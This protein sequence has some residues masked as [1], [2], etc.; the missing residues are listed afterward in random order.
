MKVNQKQNKAKEWQNSLTPLN[1]AQAGQVPIVFKNASGKK[2]T[3]YITLT[4]IE[5]VVEGKNIS[6]G[7]LLTD[8]LNMNM[9]T[10]KKVNTIEKGVA[11]HNKDL[12]IV[13]TDKLGFIKEI[14][15]F[16][17]NVDFVLA[18]QTIPSDFDKGYHYVD[19]SGEIKISEDRKLQLF[20]DFI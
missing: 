1:K 13:K 15:E 20:P 2:E 8:M 7:E 18:K 17:N 9:E 19:K 3:G 5:L 11:A 14:T 10:L 4:D 12:L 6:V 16:N